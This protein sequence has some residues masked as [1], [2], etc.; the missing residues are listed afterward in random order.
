MFLRQE[1]NEVRPFKKNKQKKVYF[2][3]NDALRIIL[4]KAQNRLPVRYYSH[5]TEQTPPFL[6]TTHT[7]HREPVTL[8]DA[9]AI[10]AGTIEVQAVRAAISVP[11]TRPPVAAAAD[12][13]LRAGV[14]VPGSS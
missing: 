7:P 4:R 11:S 6:A 8:I 3:R 9:V 13:V 5:Y 14:E 12:I 1:T 2:F 10:G